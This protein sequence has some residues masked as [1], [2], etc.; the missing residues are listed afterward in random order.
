MTVDDV[1]IDQDLA[2]LHHRVVHD[3]EEPVARSTPTT[4]ASLRSLE[5]LTSTSNTSPQHPD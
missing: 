5:R 3:P 1:Q 4:A 2:V